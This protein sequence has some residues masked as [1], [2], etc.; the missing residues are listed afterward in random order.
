[1]VRL[2]Q[3]I[4][5]DDHSIGPEDAAVT[6]VEYGTYD[7]PHCRQALAI[8]LEL[9]KEAHV[10]V[11]SLRLVYRHFPHV[12]GR[13]PAQRAAQAAEAAA[14]Q[15]RFWEMH[16]HLLKNPR[17]LDDASLLAYAAQLGLSVRQIAAALENEFRAAGVDPERPVIASCGSGLTAAIVSLAL[18]ASGHGAAAVYDGSWSEWGARED[19]PVVVD[20]R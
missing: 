17:A 2:T 4:T 20:P 13:S 9:L 5:V 8:T 1:M 10:S 7:C 12:N 3:P 14:E 11:P 18:A 6:L 19:L 16:E 15:G